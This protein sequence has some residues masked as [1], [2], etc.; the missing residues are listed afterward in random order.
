MMIIVDPACLMFS[1]DILF[2]LRS[3]LKVTTA[4]FSTVRK[5][6]LKLVISYL[7]GVKPER[8]NVFLCF[9]SF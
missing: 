9:Y 4:S 6:Q 2:K 5:V 8:C 7:A 3:L 1:H